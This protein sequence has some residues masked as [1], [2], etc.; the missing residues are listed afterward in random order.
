MKNDF[1]SSPSRGGDAVTNLCA[2]VTSQNVW[3]A[4]PRG[5]HTS[6]GGIRQLLKSSIVRNSV[7]Y[8]SWTREALRSWLQNKKVAKSQRCFRDH[9]Y[10]KEMRVETV[11]EGDYF[12]SYVIVASY[13]KISTK[14]HT[15]ITRLSNR[16]LVELWSPFVPGISWPN[17]LNTATAQDSE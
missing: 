15:T 1:R 12:D 11:N 13:V 6:L 16:C 9:R 17:I 5:M 14:P 2:S 10:S 3:I 7:S 8:A 4:P